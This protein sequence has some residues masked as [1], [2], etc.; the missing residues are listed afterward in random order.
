MYVGLK[1]ARQ[2]IP[3][4]LRRGRHFRGNITSHDYHLVYNERFP[5]G[6]NNIRAV[7]TK[8]TDEPMVFSASGSKLS[9][10]T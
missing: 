4:I 3:K 5:G 9:I 10:R 1:Y 2:P 7:V 8:K 6:L